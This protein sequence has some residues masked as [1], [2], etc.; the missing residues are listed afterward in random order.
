MARDGAEITLAPQGDMSFSDSDALSIAGRAG[1]GLA[2]IQAM[3]IAAKN[4]AC[5]NAT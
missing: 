4:D 5:Q 1:Y 3:T 2:Q